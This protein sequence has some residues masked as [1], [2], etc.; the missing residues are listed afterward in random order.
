[1]STV[2]PGFRVSK[3]AMSLK[4]ETEN[5]TTVSIN[6]EHTALSEEGYKFVDSFD[7]D[8]FNEFAAN[9]KKV[10]EHFLSTGEKIAAGT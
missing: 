1:M 4:T 9:F 2:V 5:T 7:T 3:F 6:Y 8:A 10:T